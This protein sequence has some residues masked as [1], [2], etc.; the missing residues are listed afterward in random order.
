[1]GNVETALASSIVAV[2]WAAGVVSGVLDQLAM[3]GTLASTSQ[4]QS[5]CWREV[6]SGLAFDN[7]LGCQGLEPEDGRL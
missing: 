1:M 3:L 5:L 6:P 4:R 2:A 7:Y